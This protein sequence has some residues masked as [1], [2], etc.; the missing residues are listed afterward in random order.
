MGAVNFLTAMGLFRGQWFFEMMG[1]LA[2]AA[3][4]ATREC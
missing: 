1:E 2:T 4:A 3:D